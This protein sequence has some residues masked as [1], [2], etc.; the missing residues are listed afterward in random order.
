[1]NEENEWDKDVKAEM[2]E[3]PPGIITG[4]EVEN[5]M[6]QMKK[7]RAPGTKTVNTEMLVGDVET[8]K[9][10]MTELFN[11]IIQERCIS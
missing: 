2:K 11:C 8:S 4:E 10:W 9:K 5:A 6:K 7:H 1:M 3:G